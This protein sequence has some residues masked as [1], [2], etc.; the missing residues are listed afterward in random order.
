[1]KIL[2]NWAIQKVS[3]MYCTHNNSYEFTI[4][5]SDSIFDVSTNLPLTSVT[6]PLW[7]EVAFSHK[8]IP[9]LTIKTGIHP[10]P[11]NELDKQIIQLE[12]H[13]KIAGSVI[14]FRACDFLLFLIWEQEMFLYILWDIYIDLPAHCS[15]SDPSWSGLLQLSS[16]LLDFT[17]AWICLNSLTWG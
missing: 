5:R 8:H 9:L 17:A 7:I 1:M 10:Y 13:A 12:Y 15:C 2:T 16:P 4:Q 3:V 14:L 11:L 6:N